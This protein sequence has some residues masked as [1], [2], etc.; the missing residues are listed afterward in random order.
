MISPYSQGDKNF[1]DLAK[2]R[3]DRIFSHYNFYDDVFYNNEIIF[4]NANQLRNKYQDK[5]ILIIGGGPSTNHYLSKQ[6]D[7]PQK[8]ENYDYLWSANHFF[9]NPILKD[10]KI[11]LAMFMLE[12]D[13]QSKKFV[14]YYSNFKPTLGFELHDKWIKEKIPYQDCFMMQTRFY[15]VLGACQRMLIFAGYLKAAE[16][17]F[18]GLDGVEFIKKGMHSFE[19]DKITMPSIKNVEV[20]RYQKQK[21][22][23]YLYN[24][25]KETTKF[26]D[27]GVRFRNELFK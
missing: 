15:G 11:D 16:V 26:K 3:A 20:H 21:L 1:K 12:P 19:K 14:E 8:I 9:L 13:I 10:R 2:K 7:Y 27:L 23:E 4:S 25:F 18:V 6:G 17:H 22:Y 24:H 5:K